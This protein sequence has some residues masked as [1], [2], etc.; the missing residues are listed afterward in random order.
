MNAQGTRLEQLSTLAKRLNSPRD[1]ESVMPLVIKEVVEVLQLDRGVLLVERG[2]KPGEH[3]TSH[4]RVGSEFTWE[5]LTTGRKVVSRVR[6]NGVPLVQ[7]A[8]Q[9]DQLFGPPVDMGDLKIVAGIPLHV[10]A[11]YLGAIYLDSAERSKALTR[12]DLAFL[13]SV[14]EIVSLSLTNARA[15]T[16]LMEASRMSED[17]GATLDSSEV[18]NRLLLRIVELTHAEQGFLLLRDE[19]GGKPVIWGGRDRG[20]RLLS[21]IRERHISWNIVESV[22]GDGQP[23]LTDNA[24]ADDRLSGAE[25]VA[26]F[27]LRSV[28]CVPVRTKNAVLGAVYLENRSIKGLFEEEDLQVVQ[29]VA[30]RAGM[31]MDNARL[32]EMTR[33]MVRALANAIEA[34][35][36]GTSQHVQRVSTHAVAV[37][38]KLGFDAE[39][40]MALEQSSVLHDIGKIGIPDR[41][42]LKPGKLDNE[43]WGL[44]KTHPQLGVRIIRPVGLPRM[45]KEGILC[46]QEA[47]NGSG[48]PQGLKEERIP[49]FGRIIAV[50]DAFD[51]MI[52]VRSYKQARSR[53]DVIEEVKRCRGTRYDPVVVDAFLA[54]LEEEDHAAEKS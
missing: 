47:W 12:D 42:L 25:S 24:G 7:I 32:Y 34:R 38:R 41:V 16:R 22:L 33:E 1:L 28:M 54:V 5:E 31:A 37:G 43:E 11:R 51:A 36:Y 6:A 17:L 19:D 44:M 15:Q 9:I 50:V 2:R 4:V 23:I 30:D 46:H 35:D 52:S 48:Y 10:R 8:G 39:E 45:V 49:L 26:G 21:E 27:Q 14:A 20:G 18:L 40:L 3:A 13:G 29:I 53:E